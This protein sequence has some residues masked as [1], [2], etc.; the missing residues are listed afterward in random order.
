MSAGPFNPETSAAFTVAPDVVYSPIVLAL[1]F[2]TKTSD[3][4][5]ATPTAPFDPEI[6]DEFTIAPEVVHSP[7]MLVPTLLATNKFEPD[8]A[9]PH[10]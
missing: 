5:T 6:S 4:D 9:M 3:P 1:L 7:T 10:G 2:A 8:I